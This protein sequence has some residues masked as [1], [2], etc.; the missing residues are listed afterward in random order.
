MSLAEKEEALN[1]A[2][3]TSCPFDEL[4]DYIFDKGSSGY[5]PMVSRF[6]EERLI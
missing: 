1:Y 2:A 3:K 4:N 6:D 5:K